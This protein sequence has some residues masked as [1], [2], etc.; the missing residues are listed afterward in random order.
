[1]PISRIPDALSANIGALKDFYLEVSS[2][3]EPGYSTV[4]KFGND[5]ALGAG[6][7]NP[8][9]DGSTTY[10]WPSSADI[11]HIWSAVDSATTRG[12]VVEVQGLDASWALTVQNVTTD[13]ADS[14]TE[15]G[16]TTALRRVFRMKVLDPS[17]MDQNLRVG[18]TGKASFQAQVSIG[19]N[20][21]LM[22]IYTIP[23]GKTGYM[24]NYYISLNKVSGG[25][26]PELL[27]KLWARDND[28]GYASWIKHVIGL[29]ADANSYINQT[30]N[31]Y[32]KITEKT[33][34]WLE[35]TELTGGGGV[36][37]DVSGGFDLILEDN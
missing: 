23:A 4:N 12:V 3:R 16:L 29:D 37:A 18:P 2:G 6:A 32:F 22:A 10:T 7:T 8:I 15:V 27:T 19:D 28:N 13:A 20:Q 1:M 34:V 31:P 26:N 35:S 36:I 5:P 24:T 33:D 21:T 9:W 30:F 11:T 14:T 25:G 17:V